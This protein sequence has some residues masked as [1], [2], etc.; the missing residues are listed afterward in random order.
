M[1]EICNDASL[2]LRQIDSRSEQYRSDS[3]AWILQKSANDTYKVMR[4]LLRAAKQANSWRLPSI[5][6][7]GAKSIFDCITESE[8]GSGAVRKLG[9]GAASNAFLK[10]AMNIEELLSDLS[11]EEK[12][13][14]GPSEQEEVLSS[15]M[16]NMTLA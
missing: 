3:A 2:I 13:V 11:S 5:I 4:S 12:E 9:L 15:R 1:S 10:L 7:Q 8:P 14:F 6:R 16:S